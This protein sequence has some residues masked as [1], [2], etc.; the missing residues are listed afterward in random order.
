VAEASGDGVKIGARSQELGSGV[1][2]ELLQRAGDADPA[3]VAAVAVCHGVR[4]PRLAACWVGRERERVFGYLDAKRPGLG[5][6]ALKPLLEEL[7]G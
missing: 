2:P 4:I 5:P 3:G 7:T 6:A 1:V